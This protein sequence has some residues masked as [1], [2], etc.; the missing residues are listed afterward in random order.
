MMKR[1]P[2]L[3]CIDI[4]P[5]ERTLDPRA[6]VDWTGFEKSYEI[7]SELRSRLETATGSPVHFSWFLRMDPQITHAY[8]SA[9]WVVTRYPRLFEELHSAGDELGLHTHAWRWDHHS[10][11][12]V[13]DFGDQKWI[14]H[15]VR[16]SFEAF[17]TSLKR[18]C[19]SFRFGDHWMN[20]QTLDLLERLGAQF[21]LTLEPGQSQSSLTPDEHFTGSFPDVAQ[22]PQAPYRPHTT[23]FRKR[24]VARK[25][26]LW[27][28][29]VSAGSVEWPPV[30]PVLREAALPRPWRDAYQR[31]ITL[32][33]AFN[34]MIL[35][36]IADGLLGIPWKPYLALVARTDIAI[37]PD[38]RSNLQ[39][40]IGYLLSHPLVQRFAFE[41]PAEA[42]RRLRFDPFQWWK[43]RTRTTNR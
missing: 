24:G 4:E 39:D 29:P 8:G 42:I 21:D 17:R 37:S 30:S 18:Q 41:T 16:S 11:G 36:R 34:Q 7:F 1:I 10:Q 28:I 33:L 5:D 12:W 2:V 25:R 26:D 35:S 3:I 40:N 14:D 23:D 31:C 19:R 27:M 9:H 6:R 15:C 22:V 43:R 20:D 38:Q 32:N 13:A